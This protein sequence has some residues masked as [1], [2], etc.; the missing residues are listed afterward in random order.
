[1]NGKDFDT[2][3]S[4]EGVMQILLDLGFFANILSG[5]DFIGRRD[6]YERIDGLV[7]C[8]ARR[9]DSIDWLI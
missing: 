2:K 9:L 8:L 4:N 7:M 1:M 5:G 3:V 6:I